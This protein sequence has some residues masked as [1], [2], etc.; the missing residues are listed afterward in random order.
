[1]K[2]TVHLIPQRL[3]ESERAKF[4]EVQIAAP[5]EPVAA[6]KGTG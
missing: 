1:M 5:T 4:V 3:R 6:C 2:R